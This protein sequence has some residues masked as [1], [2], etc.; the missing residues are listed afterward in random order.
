M[1]LRIILDD[2]NFNIIQETKLYIVTETNAV[3]LY[4]FLRTQVDL[5]FKIQKEK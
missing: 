1:R 5:Y 3:R 2:G 4:N